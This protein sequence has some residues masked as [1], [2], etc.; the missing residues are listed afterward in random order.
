MRHTAADY[1][2]REVLQTQGP[3]SLSLD[4]ALEYIRWRG[5]GLIPLY[6]LAMAP[7]SAIALF[8]ID[9]I[10]A[11]HRSGMAPWCIALVPATLWRWVWL[12][13]MQQVIQQ[14]LQSRPGLKL[15]LRLFW[16]LVLRLYAN[17]A[18]TWGGFFIAPAF[19]GLF[20]GGFAAPLLLERDGPIVTEMVQLIR[21][22]HHST[23][24]LFRVAVAM[25]SLMI[26]LTL[27]AFVLQMITVQ[28]VLP[29][30]L[31]MDST[32]LALTTQSTAWRLSMF[33]LILLL[34][35]FFWTVASVLLYYDSQSRRTGS[36]LR[37]RLTLVRAGEGRAP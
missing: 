5:A 21:W 24:R 27:A 11:Q 3:A 2:P 35:D 18:A 9:A 31:D 15:P 33:Y 34:F 30:F 36:D 29:S 12:A 10:S 32:A 23:S 19:Y 8:L 14:D 17:V 7:F 22:I 26:M 25:L 13:R 4:A 37:T 6:V 20:A 1:D 28:L 16:I